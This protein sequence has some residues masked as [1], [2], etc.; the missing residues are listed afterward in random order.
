MPGDRPTCDHKAPVRFTHEEDHVT[1]AD[2]KKKSREEA[3][4]KEMRE[5]DAKRKQEEREKKKKNE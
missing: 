4:K 2:R 5:K 1:M 3:K